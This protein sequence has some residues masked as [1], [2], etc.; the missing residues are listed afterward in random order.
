MESVSLIEAIKLCFHRA[1]VGMRIEFP[2]NDNLNS[3]HGEILQ[4][5]DEIV[6]A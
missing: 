4:F 1:R 6:D 2:A 5:H 3:I